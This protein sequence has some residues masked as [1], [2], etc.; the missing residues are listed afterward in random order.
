[1]KHRRSFL[2]THPVLA[3]ALA[4]GVLVGSGAL[5]ATAVGR[6]VPRAASVPA[7]RQPAPQ[8]P[9]ANGLGTAGSTPAQS[10]SAAAPSAR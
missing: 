10:K 3:V 4:V 5:A 8:Q 2:R 1:M 7:T 6:P 9:D